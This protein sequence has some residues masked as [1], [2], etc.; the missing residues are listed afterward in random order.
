M[1]Q[2]VYHLKPLADPDK[3]LE[4]LIANNVQREKSNEMKA[5][6]C[7]VLKEIEKRRAMARQAEYHGNQHE[8][9]P[10]ENLPPVQK[11][12]ITGKSRDIAAQKVGWSGKT[13]EKA[14]KVIEHIDSIKESEPEKAKLLIKALNK[15]VTGAANEI[16]PKKELKEQKKETDSLELKAGAM[17]VGF[18]IFFNYITE[19]KK[20]NWKSI[21]KETIAGY[22]N[23]LQSLI[24]ESK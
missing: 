16:R 24:D 18:Q 1:L 4:L 19:A 17:E 23:Q 9:A 5:R 22:I 10:V 11:P 13:A 8:S 2:F 15:S 7:M 6:E 21:P 14:E 20:N 12:G 3:L